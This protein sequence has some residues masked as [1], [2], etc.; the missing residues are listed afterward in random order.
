MNQRRNTNFLR[1]N[2]WVYLVY[3]LIAVAAIAVLWNRTPTQRKEVPLSSIAQQV[4]AGN[5]SKIIVRENTL[6][7][8]Q[9][10]GTVV[11]SQKEPGTGL[12]ETLRSFGVTPERLSAVE[13]AIEQ[14]P[15][16]SWILSLIWLLPLFI[17]FGFFLMARRGMTDGGAGQAF[18]FAKSRA[19]R[20][21]ADR[22]AVRFDDVAGVEEAKQEL[23]EVV[24]FLRSPQ[25]FAAL[26]ARIPK[27]VLLVGSPGTG[28]TL[29]ARAVAGE[30]AVPFFSM[31]GSEFV[32][33]FVGVGASRVRDLFEQ[34]KQHAPCIIFID[35]IDAVGRQRG[36][37]LGGGHDEREQTLNQ[38]LTEMDGF[39]KTV[40]VIVMAATNR[41]DVLDPA[42]LRPGRFDRRVTL[43]LPDI[44]GRLAILRIHARGKPLDD[45]VDLDRIGRLTPGFSGAD[46]ENLMN[47]AALLAA[48]RN[49]RVILMS[50]LEDAIDRV[51]IGPEKRT[52]RMTDREKK[53][54]AYHEGGH[55]IVAHL[56][57]NAD[58]VH[59][60]SIIARGASGGHT[61]LLP[62]EDRHFWSKSQLT[63]SLAYAL[64]GMAAE[65]L[66]FGESTTGPGSDLEHATRTA[67]R[68]VSRFGMSKRVGPVVFGT[69]EEQIFLG[70]EFTAARS[71]SDETAN[72]ID[73]EIRRLLDEARE[74]AIELLTEN[75]KRL[76]DLAA[77]LMER[78]TLQGAELA[79]ALDGRP[80]P[81]PG[82]PEPVVA[83]GMGASALATEPS[84]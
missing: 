66:I 50:D 9:K 36:A 68:M 75:R 1:G 47:E 13:I 3:A 73:E 8:Q 51:V 19:R 22:P 72:I 27:G 56:L 81:E 64:G 35:E 46:L 34:A 39:E 71:H 21:T 33:L 59:K 48:R 28:K 2:V 57:P 53:L 63:D 31:S 23:V 80:L 40:S 83:S 74:R 76:D 43:D 24:E 70:R 7:V 84:P 60:I 45:G 82:V 79:A 11:D 61:R 44:D 62:E 25:K 5:V 49:R 54:T 16:L 15:D 69:D 67:R 58:P 30:A 6:R 38:I 18:S 32:E 52:R 12:T 14:P 78:E 37:G 41:P 10:D 4:E 26:G 29:L 42:L 17:I 77:L 65:E 55:A 20:I